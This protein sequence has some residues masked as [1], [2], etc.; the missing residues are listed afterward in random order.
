MYTVT[1]TTHGALIITHPR[2]PGLAWNHEAGGWIQ[3]CDGVPIPRFQP[4]YFTT[5]DEA[6]EYATANFLYPRRD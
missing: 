4:T 3:H 1:R 6:D 2:Q 5:E